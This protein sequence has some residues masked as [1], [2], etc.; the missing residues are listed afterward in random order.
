MKQKLVILTG[1]L[2]VAALSV[3]VFANKSQDVEKSLLMRNVEAIAQDEDGGGDWGKDKGP[4][5]PWE[6]THEYS[7]R[8]E[9]GEYKPYLRVISYGCSSS[10]HPNYSVCWAGQVYLFLNCSGIVS[11]VYEDGYTIAC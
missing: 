5:P 11:D 6:N 8:C 4:C 1:S 9:N 2:M 10:G 7:D 3:A